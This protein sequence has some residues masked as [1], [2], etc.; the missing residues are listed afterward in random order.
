MNAAERAQFARM[1]E[2]APDEFELSDPEKRASIGIFRRLQLLA[3]RLHDRFGDYS[4]GGDPLG[5]R[6]VELIQ[7]GPNTLTAIPHRGI[8]ALLA[9]IQSLY[10]TLQVVLNTERGTSDDR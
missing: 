7:T 1:Y 10:A 5:R 6:C 9:E 3:E 4:D 2:R 8:A